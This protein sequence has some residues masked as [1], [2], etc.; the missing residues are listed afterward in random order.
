MA[1]SAAGKREVACRRSHARGGA[2]PTDTALPDALC[3]ALV[4]FNTFPP[5][6]VRWHRRRM[7]L[8]LEVP[9]LQA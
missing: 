3:L 8:L 5:A 1:P 6:E 9:A 2:L 7:A 4:D